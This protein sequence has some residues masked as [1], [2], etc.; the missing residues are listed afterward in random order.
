MCVTF[1]FTLFY[2]LQ[3]V[4]GNK[5]P[6]GKSTFTFV[7]TG[8]DTSEMT[9][10]E[11]QLVRKIRQ[12]T[13]RVGDRLEGKG[14]EDSKM[15]S[16]L[17]DSMTRFVA[18]KGFGPIYNRPR[19]TPFSLMNP[20]TLQ[21]VDS[22]ATSL[23]QQWKANQIRDFVLKTA[24]ARFKLTIE[25]VCFQPGGCSFES[26]QARRLY[27]SY[28]NKYI[29]ISSKRQIMSTNGE[30][31]ARKATTGLD[32]LHQA[33]AL[34]SK[35]SKVVVHKVNAPELVYVQDL[36]SNPPKTRIQK[37]KKVILEVPI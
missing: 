2:F 18:A 36:E 10:I 4:F 22:V 11:E 7:V 37:H 27:D 13:K 28:G 23:I 5:I 29:Q 8:V 6:H 9:R 24:A 3:H 12:F 34:T 21:V 17:T 31:K 20:E 35:I 19:V 32:L 30:H 1:F 14:V 25:V 16:T 33:S 15:E 26:A